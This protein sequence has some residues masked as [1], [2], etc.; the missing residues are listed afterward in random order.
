ML[1]GEVTRD[2]PSTTKRK[3]GRHW[4]T[5]AGRLTDTGGREDWQTLADVLADVQVDV[6]LLGASKSGHALCI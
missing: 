5:Q 1:A 6:Q 4:R 2:R 3:A